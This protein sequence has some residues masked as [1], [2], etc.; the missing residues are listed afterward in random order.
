MKH[1][2]KWIAVLLSAAL[3]LTVAPLQALP[4]FAGS[5]SAVQA[6][7]IALGETLTAVVPEEEEALAYFRFI[8]ET[9]GFYEFVSLGEDID[10]YGYLYNADMELILENDDGEIDLNF[11]LREYFRAGRTYYFG[12]CFYSGSDSGSFP[13][14]LRTYTGSDDYWCR[15]GRSFYDVVPETSLTLSMDAWVAVGV[16][17]YQWQNAEMEDIE[18][19]TDRDFT[20]GPLLFST[21][22]YCRVNLWSADVDEEGERTLEDWYTYSFYIEINNRLEAYAA[23]WGENVSVVPGEDVELAV[24]ASCEKGAPSYQWYDEDGNPIED[25]IYANYT[26]YDVTGPAVYYCEVSDDYGSDPVTVRFCIKMNTGLS[27]AYPEGLSGELNVLPGARTALGAVVTINGDYA[28]HCQWFYNDELQEDETGDTFLTPALT[29][30]DARAYCSVTDDYGNEEMLSYYLIRDNGFFAYAKNHT[31]DLRVISWQPAT[32]TVETGCLTGTINYRWQVETELYDEEYEY[33]YNDYVDIE[34]ASGTIRTEDGVVEYTTPA[35]TAQAK[36]RCVLMD[37]FEEKTVDFT[38]T[39]VDVTE[40]A[41]NTETETEISDAGDWVY[42]SFTPA[43]NGVYHFYSTG[44]LDTV[45]YLFDAGWNRLAYNDDSQGRN[46]LIEYTLTA[47]Q[48]YYYGAKLYGDR[49]G[50]FYVRLKLYDQNGFYACAENNGYVSVKAGNNATLAVTAHADKGV[51][52]Y[53]WCDEN[54]DPIEGQTGSTFTFEPMKYEEHYSCMVWDDYDNSDTVDFNVHVDN[55]FNAAAVGS[56]TVKVPYGET[57]ELAV[58]ATAL[59]PGFT[60]QWCDIMFDPIEGETGASFTTPAVTAYTRYYCRVTD[61]YGGYDHVPF[62]VTVD[63]SFSVEPAV[64][65]SLSVRYGG[66]VT[67]QVQVTAANTEGLTIVWRDNYGD[68]IP[69]ETGTSLSVTGVTGSAW[70]TCEVTDAYENYDDVE[71]Y[72]RVDTGFS[73]QARDNEPDIRVPYGAPAELVVETT[74][75]EG[76]PV[77]YKWYDED[78]DLIEGVTGNTYTVDAVTGYQ[79]Y[80]CEVR[81]GCGKWETIDFTV[82]VD[83]GLEAGA[84][85]GETRFSVPYGQTQELVVEATANAGVALT[86]EWKA[87]HSVYDDEYGWYWETETLPEV[88]G[89]VLVAGPLTEYTE[90]TCTVSDPYGC[91]EIITFYVSVDTGLSVK[92]KDDRTSFTVAYGTPL[93]LTVEASAYEGVE[94]TYRWARLEMTGVDGMYSHWTTVQ[95]PDE[96]GAFLTVPSVTTAVHYRCVVTDSCGNEDDVTFYIEVANAL[97]A[98]AEKTMFLVPPGGSVTFRVTAS[99][100]QGP[101]TYSWYN[102]N[103]EQISGDGAERTVTV[104]GSG[105]WYCVV[106]DSYGNY[107][108]VRFNVICT[109]PVPLVLRGENNA[110][111]KNGNDIVLFSFTPEETGDYV[112]WSESDEDTYVTL[113]SEDLETLRHDDDGGEG[114]NF[115]LVYTLEAGRTYYYAVRYL[116]NETGTIPVQF[117]LRKDNGFDAYPMNHRSDVYVPYGHP[118][119]LTVVATADDG[120]LYYAWKNSSGDAMAANAPGVLITGPIT[121]Y[122][123]FECVVSDDYG[124]L[125]TVPFFVH[126]DNRFTVEAATPTSVYVIPGGSVTMAVHASATEGPFTYSWYRSY[127]NVLVEGADGPSLT[128]ENV[129]GYDT[130]VCVVRDPF[131]AEQSV[132]FYISPDNGFFVRPRDDVSQIF[133]NSGERASLEIEVS[134]IQGDIEC[135]WYT[136]ETY[137]D[138][139]GDTRYR[140]VLLEG[141]TGRKLLTDPITHYT[142]YCCYVTDETGETRSVYFYVNVTGGL[143][144]RMMND[145]RRVFVPYGGSVTL[146]PGLTAGAPL[147]YRWF[148]IVP[149]EEGYDSVEMETTASSVT[150]GPVTAADRYQCLIS[151]PYGMTEYVYFFVTVDTGLSAEYRD[152]TLYTYPGGSVELTTDVTPGPGYTFTYQWYDNSSKLDETGSTLQVNNVTKTSYYYCAVEDGYGSY[153]EYYYTVIVTE[154]PVYNWRFDYGTCTAAYCPVGGTAVTET[155][156]VAVSGMSST[157]ATQGVAVYTAEFE[158]PAFETQT[159]TVYNRA[160]GHLWSEWADV[161]APTCVAPGAQGRSC[162]RCGAE[163]TRDLPAAGHAWGEPAYE[164]AADYSTVTATRVC[165]NDAS[166]VET[167]T[168]GAT[169]VETGSGCYAAGSVLYTSD[170]FENP[171][172]TVQTIEVVTGAANHDWGDPTYVWAEDHSTV[173]ATRVCRRD[174]G[175]TESETV[176]AEYSETLAPGCLT[177]GQGV[178]TSAAFANPAFTVQ[179]FTVAVDALGHLFTEKTATEQYLKTPATCTTAAVYYK[180]CA[181]CHAA[182]ET[183]TF[184]SGAAL[185]HDWS[186]WA[187]TAAPTCTEAGEETRSCSRCHVTETR[188]VEALGHDFS[189]EAVADYYLK[190]E[191]TCTEP[192]VYYKN[193]TRCHAASETAT[194]TSGEALGH[195]WS[196]WAGLTAPTCTAKGTETRS[197]ARCQVTETHDVDALGHDWSDWTETAAPTCTA[198]GEETRTCGRCHITETRPVEKRAHNFVDQYTTDAYLKSAATCT[199]AAVYYYR[200]LVCG[201]KGTATYSFGDPL[202]HSW[203]AWTKLDDN[204]HQRVCSRDASHKETAAHTWDEGTVTAPATPTQ[205]GEKTF[206]CSVCGGKKKQTLAQQTATDPASGIGVTYDES[207]YPQKI[208]VK[209]VAVDTPETGLPAT[210]EKTYSVDV[211]TLIGNREVEPAAPVTV[212]VPVPEGFDVKSLAV[213]HIKDD[214]TA[215]K[216]DFTVKNGRIV[217][218]AFAF[219]VYVVVDTSTEASGAVLGDVD[220]DGEITAADARLALRRAVDLETY[221]PGS[222]EFTACDVDKDG[223]VTAADARK[224]LRAAV[225]L[226]DPATW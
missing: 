214:G 184:E 150:V 82:S 17:T 32:L 122:T 22:Y 167:E 132:Y 48:T 199:Q 53:Q 19:A 104:T 172:F 113:Y 42:Y 193:C 119:T 68:V 195:N 74:A 84:K 112:I 52:H 111:I 139:Y 87:E 189:A 10:T 24:A 37:P 56:T 149:D 219:S 69:G 18:G 155:V 218:T 157:C 210:Y 43:E 100:T 168:V 185:G 76:V 142:E 94:L 174:P 85:D 66:D 89:G 127:G 3:L 220:F 224:I 34:D 137:T 57:A 159:R 147:T 2:Q 62:E 212:S 83:S 47:G 225:E 80:Y 75:Y 12:V 21:T 39:P 31:P 188:P 11:C 60:Y 33:T 126:V 200:C 70:Y 203:G 183:E 109:E 135:E 29:D 131:G 160:L 180:S 154:A 46:F 190:S 86:Y 59:V 161:T 129:T 222:K 99:C 44:E 169:G 50:T 152:V 58:T 198:E 49:T 123:T 7:D 175:H 1:L 64:D 191:A 138:A 221:A 14:T 216:V 121:E 41:L 15:G 51:L 197:C 223:E 36:Y 125:Q 204:Q 133:V 156:E 103:N 93:T 117:L 171:A 45:G 5:G 16:I 151:D 78:Y 153:M 136:Y 165:A 79:E 92:A 144:L 177:P 63:N 211:T 13:V 88:T 110:V 118:A 145:Y 35:I 143:P 128:V 173:T 65:T 77:T 54:G 226:E 187:E 202:G 90:Y 130:Y 146:A 114:M 20:T 97:Q 96:T 163:E 201:A 182:S 27:V 102:N 166:H 81:D 162:A 30:F 124:N 215:E 108:Q 4:A 107:A 120:E 141:E 40:I 105:V 98:E 205:P 207:A 28:Y 38:V 116:F 179:T 67:L 25:E 194:F 26:V 209:V 181:R 164:W 196:D 186:D 158:N 8:P 208:T 73:A 9:D 6:T 95:L 178:Y 192:A 91:S 71:F 115:R 170:P 140:S 148:H 23:G 134:F 55:E 213:Y 106:R 101:V 61:A 176:S 72:V 217:F 206:T